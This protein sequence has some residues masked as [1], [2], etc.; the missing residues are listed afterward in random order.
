VKESKFEDF[1]NFENYKVFV[2]TM[3][4][5]K[6]KEFDNVYLLV[7]DGKIDSDDERRLLYVGITR[8]KRNLFIHTNSREFDK[9]LPNIKINY[10]N[11]R[12][13]FP[14]KIIM[15][16]SHKGVFLSLFKAD[17]KKEEILRKYIAGGELLFN[18]EEYLYS[19]KGKIK[20]MFKLSKEASERI[21]H[22]KERGYIIE[23]IAIRFVVAWKEKSDNDECAI[24]LPTITLKRSQK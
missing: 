14:E 18:E 13:N 19:P 8:A 16:L 20:K 7:K 12:Y 23:K 11:T 2:S 4:K 24:V 15:H 3:H 22:W 5:A 21:S 1:V 10:I 9:L 6:G 17:Y